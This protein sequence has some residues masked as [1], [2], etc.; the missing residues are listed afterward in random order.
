MFKVDNVRRDSHRMNLLLRSLARN[1]STTCTTKKIW[2]DICVHD[3]QSISIDTVSDYLS[4]LEQLFVTENIP[5]FSAEIRSPIRVKQAEKHHFPDPSLPAS[6]L[7]LTEEKLIA[8]LRTFGFLFE[9]LCLRDLLT[10]ASASK[11]EVY[12]Y[13]DYRNNEIDA[14]VEMPD[15]E[16][17]AFEIKLGANQIDNATSNL[18]KISRKF[19]EG[20]SIA[21]KVLCVIC[22]M[23]IAAYQ[24]PDGVYVIPLTALK[25]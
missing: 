11:A 5:P 9:S 24:R 4:V 2:Q 1:E 3:Y 22:G 21:P 13:Q 7:H 18:L 8:D 23:S 15:G 19:R 12:H 10:Y 25:D 16:W 6:L 20:G 14:V 17:G